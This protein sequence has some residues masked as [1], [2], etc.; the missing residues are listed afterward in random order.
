[1][2]MK[3]DNNNQLAPFIRW[4]CIFIIIGG[5]K[6][7]SDIL[8]PFFLALFISI[9]A[10]QPVNWLIKKG[11][12]KSISII[13][14]MLV[15]VTFGVF[16]G[17]IIG[18]SISQF[19][20]NLPLLD[21]SFKENITS[22]TVSINKLG[23]NFSDARI[24]SLIDPGKILQFTAT[25]IS[26]MGNILGQT[27]I[28]ILISL[29]VLF[30]L[31]SFP[32]KYK[33]VSKN[34]ENKKRKKYN[35]TAII[36]NVRSY[37]YVKT[38]ISLAAGI[39]TAVGLKILGIQ[40]AFFW[41][42][43]AFLMNYIPNIG[44]I[45]AALPVVAFALIGY[46]FEKV[47]WTIA[48]YLFINIIE[49]IVEPKIMGNDFGLSTLVVLLSLLFWGWVFGPI[50]MFLS[51]PFTMI[52]K[53]ILETNDQSQWLST[54]LNSEKNIRKQWKEIQNNEENKVV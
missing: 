17:G 9:I 19:T 35:F 23:F 34:N 13:L 6:I 32:I 54:W 26:S 8:T 53:I 46:G 45:L 51:V 39:L 21:Q 30:E 10:S 7:A 22:F 20:Q 14:V 49:S 38:M 18:T 12:P 4:A 48:I 52:L 43:I 50:G 1:M 33:V 5:M 11:I 31:D 41:G 25:T 44:S 3:I 2:K 47:I 28:I 29:F 40:Y 27:L 15:L 36:N 24:A 16:V 42:L 37:L